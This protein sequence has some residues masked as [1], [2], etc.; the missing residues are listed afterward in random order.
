MRRGDTL[1]CDLSNADLEEALRFRM[2]VQPEENVKDDTADGITQSAMRVWRSTD[3]AVKLANLTDIG[4][5]D[6]IEPREN[7]TQLCWTE[8][9]KTTKSTETVDP[10][11]TAAVADLS[12]E[13]WTAKYKTWYHEVFI[14]TAT[15]TPNELQTIV[16]HTIH[17]R[18]FLV[19]RR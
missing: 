6:C 13:S 4:R 9:V 7:I 19:V 2:P 11:A 5:K 3:L 16:L 15:K 12:T 14:N 10:Y 8:P 1:R 17:D 18:R